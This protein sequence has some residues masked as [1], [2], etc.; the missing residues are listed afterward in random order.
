MNGWPKSRNRI[1]LELDRI[2]AML[3]R[4]GGRGYEVREDIES[5]GQI[6]ID[7]DPDFDNDTTVSE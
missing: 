1:K 7:P 6:E 2:A 4:L 5:Y 3:S